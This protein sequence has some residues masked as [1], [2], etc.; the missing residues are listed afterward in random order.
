MEKLPF[1]IRGTEFHDDKTV[2]HLHV[3]SHIRNTKQ[4]EGF[5]QKCLSKHPH[6]KYHLCENDKCL[7]FP[8][9]LE[10]T[11]LAH[12]FEHVLLDLIGEKDKSVRKVRGF[13]AWD[14]RKFEQDTYQIHLHY[15]D[16]NVFESALK[17]AVESFN[18]LFGTTHVPSPIE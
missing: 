15:T 6:L 8:E 9:E 1:K 18:Y 10:E 4:I 12:A 2:I 7:S 13:T 3:P 5:S 17:D 14:W 16:K 11:E